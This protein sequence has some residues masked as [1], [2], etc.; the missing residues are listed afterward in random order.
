[1]PFANEAIERKYQFLEQFD[2]ED[3]AKL[4]GT[5]MNHLVDAIRASSPS[6]RQQALDKAIEAC[7]NARDGV[8][9]EI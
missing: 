7:E 9:Y 8:L 4:D 2:P 5:F 1:M 3:A 6:E